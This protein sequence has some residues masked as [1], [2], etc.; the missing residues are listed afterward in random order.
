VTSYGISYSQGFSPSFSDEETEVEELTMTNTKE[1]SK[2][3]RKNMTLRCGFPLERNHVEEEGKIYGISPVAHCDTNCP[4][5][6]GTC[7]DLCSTLPIT[8][9]PCLKEDYE[10]E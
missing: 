9:R 10:R 1:D 4:Y 5:T 6:V 2:T 3:K 8:Q 7:L